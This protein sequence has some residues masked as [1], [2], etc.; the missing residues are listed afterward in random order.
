M[1][2]GAEIK[3]VRRPRIVTT[4]AFVSVVLAFSIAPVAAHFPTVQGATAV[5]PTSGAPGSAVKASATGA[6]PGTPYSLMFADPYQVSSFEQGGGAEGHKEA[7][8][9][10]SP[11][12]GP[13][14]ADA[15]GNIATVEATIPPSSP[16]R[17][18]I[19]FQNGNSLTGP[20]EFT[21]QGGGAPPMPPYRG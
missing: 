3:R 20:A 16:G 12:A 17:A 19:C 14:N 1:S 15:T 13:M 10:G 6:Q 18:L 4:A 11:I 5:D 7:C 8:A 21:V 9:H 2:A